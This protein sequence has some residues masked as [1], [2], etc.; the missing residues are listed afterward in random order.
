MRLPALVLSLFLATAVLLA[1]CAKP[2][3]ELPLAENEVNPPPGAGDAPP[4]TQGQTAQEGSDAG[5]DDGKDASEGAK[6]KGGAPPA[7][8]SN[9]TAPPQNGTAPPPP[10]VA[11]HTREVTGEGHA[12]L[13]AGLPCHAPAPCPPVEHE[14]TP[15][16]LA[17]PEKGPS[18]GSLVVTWEAATETAKNL[19]F[20]ATASDGT[21]LG[22]ASGASPL[23]IALDASLLAA[24][25]EVV[26]SLVPTEPGLVAQQ[27]YAVVLTLRYG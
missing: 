13:K 27:D 10:A 8:A 11:P 3:D 2:A 9:G 16:T 15:A 23:A 6:D 5:A 20:N 24:A 22:A 25:G 21:L 7:T 18:A 1:G 17:I 4:E 12:G 14:N 19:H 26:V